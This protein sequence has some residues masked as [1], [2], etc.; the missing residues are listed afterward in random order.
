MWMPRLWG[1]VAP[2]RFGQLDD[3]RR[4]RVE[5]DG[6]CRFF[7]GAF[8]VEFSHSLNDAGHVAGGG[9]DEFQFFARLRAEIL[10]AHQ[11]QFGVG[12]HGRQGVADVVGNA[13]RH[14]AQ[15]PQ[16]L[17]LH[18]EIL[19]LSPP[20][21]GPAQVLLQGRLIDGQGHMHR[22]V[23]HEVKV[24]GIEAVRLSPP[25]QQGPEQLL[26][27]LHGGGHQRASRRVSHA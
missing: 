19:R 14:G 4:Q 3:L 26:L 7:A 15:G 6:Q 8:A 10:L 13:G 24:H 16:T 25:H 23:L 5:V 20:F 11:Q 18:D 1:D 22:Q 9:G 2:S 27:G 21:M 12:G 17:L